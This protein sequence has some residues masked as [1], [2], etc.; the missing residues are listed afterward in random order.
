MNQNDNLLRMQ[1]LE[2]ENGQLTKELE[3]LRS[4]AKRYFKHSFASANIK[5][6]G[7]TPHDEALAAESARCLMHALVRSPEFLQ[8]IHGAEA[9]VA[10]ALTLTQSQ[11]VSDL[12]SE[13]I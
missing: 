2:H 7:K 6:V 9:K 3:T 11:T 13:Q 4:L 5:L 12:R 1:R 10:D 8:S